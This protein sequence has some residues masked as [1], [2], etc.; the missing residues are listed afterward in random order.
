MLNSGDI[1]VL[2]QA[3]REGD[4]S[5]AKQVWEHLYANLRGIATA[6]MARQ[7]N[8]HTLSPT[9]VV[10]EAYMRLFQHNVVSAS[11]R[12]HFLSL[13]AKAMRALLV[14]H[15]RRKGSD[16]RGGAWTRVLLEES[17]AES[18]AIR[19]PDVQD[20]HRS[21]ERLAE[22]DQDLASLVELRYFAGMTIKEVAT[23][24]GVGVTSVK[25]S[26]SFAKAWL[27]RDMRGLNPPPG[28]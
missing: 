7:P 25:E 18:P 9:A 11:D 1:T 15:A 27:S 22:Y 19:E 13:A 17:S 5:A 21:L 2:L 8:A 20:L 4:D 28:E 3:A 6:L 23:T 12:R 26:W 16:K 24:T 10:H 14:D